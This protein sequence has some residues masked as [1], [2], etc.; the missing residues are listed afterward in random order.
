MGP[1]NEAGGLIDYKSS[2]PP[3]VE[4]NWHHEITNTQL[5]I[6]GCSLR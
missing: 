6:S 5:V 4:L 2:L 1:A 3:S